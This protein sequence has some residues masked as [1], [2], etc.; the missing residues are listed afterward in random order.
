MER[1]DFCQINMACAMGGFA[2]FDVSGS[3]QTAQILTCLST[4][5][6]LSSTSGA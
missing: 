3:D 5:L 6:S 1:N 4:G 2:I